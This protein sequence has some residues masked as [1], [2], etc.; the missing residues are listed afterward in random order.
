MQDNEMKKRMENYERIIREI[1]GAFSKLEFHII[2]ESTIHRKIIPVDKND[3]KDKLLLED[4]RTIVNDFAIEYNRTPITFNLYKKLV[5]SPKPKSFRN[6]E[7]GIFADKM[8]PSFFEKNKNKLKIIN[9]FERLQLMGYP[10]EKITD[11]YGRVTYLEVK[12]TSRRDVGSP[13]DFFFS[14]LTNSKK[15]VTDDGHH[16]LLCFDTLERKEKEFIIIGWCLIDLFGI[17]VSIKPEFNTDNLELY[18]KENILLEFNLNR[19]K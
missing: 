16:L 5:K 11:R 4:I 1:L 18:R 19:N 2:V 13:R 9:S 7:V 14:P 8:I 15:K 6:N 3:E 10:D 12:A 17:K